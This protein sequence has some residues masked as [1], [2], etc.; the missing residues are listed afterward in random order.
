M[1]S[2][3]ERHVIN[4]FVVPCFVQVPAEFSP[5][6]HCVRCGAG[7]DGGAGSLSAGSRFDSLSSDADESLIKPSISPG[8]FPSA[9][10]TC[11]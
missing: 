9:E 7:H 1:F 11:R 5:P 3:A 4:M 2:V 6:T 8:C 10:K